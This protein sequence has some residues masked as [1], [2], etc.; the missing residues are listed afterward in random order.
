[1]V[2]YLCKLVEAEDLGGYRLFMFTDN[3]TAEAAFWKGTSVS[4][5]LFELVLQLKRLKLERDII[6]HVVHISGK[7][8]IAQGTDG[9][10]QADH[11]EGVMHGKP[12]QDFI[13]LHLWS[14]GKGAWSQI[15]ASN[16]YG[17]IGSYLPQALRMVH[18]QAWSWN[19]HLDH[20]SGGC[21]GG[22]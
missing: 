16:D 1:L 10:S 19:L 8:M 6:L 2:L 5:C 9:L 4:P 22:G 11:L 18:N 17:Q 13:L 21:Q 7:W 12:I 14:I 15:L 20:A 3:S